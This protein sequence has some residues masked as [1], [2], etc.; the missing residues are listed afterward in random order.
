MKRHLLLI[1]FIFLSMITGSGLAQD[2]TW[3]TTTDYDHN[4]SIQFPGVPTEV[5]KNA[6]EG[7]KYTTYVT[8]GQSS[9]FLKVMDLKS[10]PADKKAKAQKVINSLATKAK[11]KVIEG[12][13]WKEGTNT[14]VQG[15]IEIS[16]TGKPEMLVFC[17]VM[18]IGKVQYE[19][20]VMTPKEIYDPEFDGYFLSS[21]RFL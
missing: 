7:T 11:G 18:I 5:F 6:S 14:G 20:I 8:Y 16:Q 21:F 2:I 10:E 15:K 12:N 19:I 3:S 9:Y 1:S 17:N 4:C 13:D